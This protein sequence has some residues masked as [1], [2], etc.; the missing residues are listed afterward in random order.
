MFQNNFDMVRQ[1]NA[2]VSRTCGGNTQMIYVKKWNAE[3]DLNRY[4]LFFD[5]KNEWLAS[6]G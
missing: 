5:D 1:D 6:N 3:F 4:L 2:K